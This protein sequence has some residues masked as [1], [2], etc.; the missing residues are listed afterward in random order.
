M[1]ATNVTSQKTICFEGILL[2]ILDAS[3][4][5]RMILERRLCIID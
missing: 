2:D 3:Y 4:G 5:A 1:R